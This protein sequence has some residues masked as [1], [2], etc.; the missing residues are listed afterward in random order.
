MALNKRL[1][2]ARLRQELA[3]LKLE[4]DARTGAYN[5]NSTDKTEVRIRIGT[6]AVFAFGAIL[7]LLIGNPPAETISFV[8]AANGLLN[9]PNGATVTAKEKVK[10]PG[11]PGRG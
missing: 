3:R 4:R 11:S 2:T 9:W 8:V 5:E 6:A 10:S 1:Q 7:S